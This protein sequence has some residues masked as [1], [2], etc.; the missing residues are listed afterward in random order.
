MTERHDARAFPPTLRVVENDDE[1]D[2]DALAVLRAFL[3]DPL[4]PETG[5]LIAA[6]AERRGP[7]GQ[8]RAEAAP[9][10]L[11]SDN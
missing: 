4:S 5:A 3:L 7:R 9:G 1:V 2:L 8:L 6:H 10:G 11:L